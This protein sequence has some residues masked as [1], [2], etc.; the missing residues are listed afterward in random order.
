VNK[1]KEL[2]VFWFNGMGIALLFLL[3][4]TVLLGPLVLNVY[5][6]VTRTAWWGPMLLPTIVWAVTCGVAFQKWIDE[7]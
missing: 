7:K 1:L 3:G 2:F 6:M 4:L 5:L